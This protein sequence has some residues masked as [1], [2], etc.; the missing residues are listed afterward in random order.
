MRLNAGTFT[1]RHS[2]GTVIAAF[3]LVL[4]A[5]QLGAATITTHWSFDSDFTATSGTDLNDATTVGGDPSVSSTGSKLGGGH[6]A[7][8]GN[9]RL[10]V[11]QVGDYELGTGQL[12][13]SFWFRDAGSSSSDR[14]LETGA[15]NNGTE[16]YAMFT[17]TSNGMS[18]AASDGSARTILKSDANNTVDLFD[19]DWHFVAVAMDNSGSNPTYSVNVWVDG[20]LETDATIWYSNSTGVNGSVGND[21]SV[22]AIGGSALSGGRMTGDIDDLAIYDGLLT[23][24]NVARLYNSGDGQTAPHFIPE[25]TTLALLAL[26]LTAVL[27][28]RPRRR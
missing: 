26:G 2:I 25:P 10:D 8:D 5:G 6:G 7:F 22:L 14:V 12:S 17:D 15:I 20:V 27:G 24:E 13:Y 19:N 1:L 16:G 21:S 4:T 28:R 23:Q 18:A 11:S 9:D 3:V